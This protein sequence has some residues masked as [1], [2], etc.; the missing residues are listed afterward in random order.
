MREAFNYMFKDNLFKQKWA[1]YFCFAF[2]GGLFTNLGNSP[3][4]GSFKAFAPLFLLIGIIIMFIPSG[5]IVA[6]IRALVEQKENYVLPLFNF[7]NNLLT[8]FKFW[9]AVLILSLIFGVGC[10]VASGIIAV[11]AGLLKA[12]VVALIGI[13]FIMVLSLLI[14][15]FYTVA[16]NRIFAD[17]DSWLSFI[18]FKHATELIKKS[19]QYNKAFLLF[20]LINVLCG[21]ISGILFAIWGRTIEGLIIVTII[22]SIIA[23]Y[24]AFINAFITAK[25]ID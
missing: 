25:A 8:G 5:Y 15:A 9:I 4:L 18:K 6:C 14:V 16:L 7:K 24:V 1:A 11:I 22:S 13:T 17:T 12:R 21:I 10:A 3:A 19:A 2:F 23:S 20:I